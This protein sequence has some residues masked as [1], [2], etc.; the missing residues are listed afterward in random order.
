MSDQ[1]DMNDNDS[2]AN[3]ELVGDQE[4]AEMHCH[5]SGPTSLLFCPFL[6][7]GKSKLGTKL[8]VFCI[9]N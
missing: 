2:D 7:L 6:A 1:Q 8:C 4:L 9:Q 3:E 5:L